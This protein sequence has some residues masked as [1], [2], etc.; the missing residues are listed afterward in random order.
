MKSRS[1]SVREPSGLMMKVSQFSRSLLPA[2]L[3]L[4]HFGLLRTLL[5]S[6]RI[7]SRRLPPS[8]TARKIEK[9]RFVAPGPVNWFSVD[10]PSRWPVGCAQANGS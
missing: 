9:S 4:D 3:G 2:E 10:V 7:S 6:N 1:L 5:A 8:G